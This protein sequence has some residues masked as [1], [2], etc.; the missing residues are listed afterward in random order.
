[1][2][3]TQLEGHLLNLETLFVFGACLS[4]AA[5]C[6][7]QMTA[8]F[9]HTL[10]S[11]GKVA[12]SFVM[13]LWGMDSSLFDGLFCFPILYWSTDSNIHGINCNGRTHKYALFADGLYLLI[14]PSVISLPN[15]T[16]LLQSL[17]LAPGPQVSEH[18]SVV[19]N[20]NLP[21]SL[22]SRLQDAFSFT[23]KS[24]YMSLT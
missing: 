14:I 19:M 1:M 11:R 8:V 18:K 4:K 21:A 13:N 20:I 23:W 9:K 6:L 10:V 5:I 7:W 16:P 22:V 17:R 3:V 2:A 24:D 15:L 12:E